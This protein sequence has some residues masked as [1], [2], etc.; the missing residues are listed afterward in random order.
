M[1][2]LVSSIPGLSKM[3]IRTQGDASTNTR[4]T[5]VCQEVWNWRGIGQEISAKVFK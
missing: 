3:E 2:L 5:S 4:L 1:Q